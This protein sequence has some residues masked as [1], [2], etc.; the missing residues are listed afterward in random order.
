M[1]RPRARILLVTGG[2]GFL[3]RH[4][5][6]SASEEWAI[7]APSS[8]ALDIVDRER[9]ITTIRELRPFAIAHLAYRRD[10]RQVIVVGSRNVAEAAASVGARL[11]HLSTDV[12]FPGRSA[13]Y[14]E[15]DPT[16][17]ISDYARAKVDAEDAVRAAFPAAVLIRTSLLYGTECLG[18]CQL[19][20]RRALDDPSAMSFFRDEVRSF[21]HAADVA[22]AVFS[23]AGQ[24]EI[25]GPLHVAG[26]EPL[27]RLH[28]ARLVARRLGQSDTGLV[29]STIAASGLARSARVVLDSSR[30]IA[31]GLSCRAVSDALG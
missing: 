7:V 1:A 18:A 16:D 12:V 27:D 6:D 20:V 26:P 25:S 3:G 13:P 11:I 31:F 30:A 14:R 29:G 15:E 23:L 2:S 19:D 22:R 28:F 21:T 10:D 9:V 17:P 4:L 8:Q 5:L 24:P